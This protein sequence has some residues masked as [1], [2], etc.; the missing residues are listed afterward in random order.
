MLAELKGAAAGLD[1][2]LRLRLSTPLYVALVAAWVAFEVRSSMDAV[3]GAESFIFDWD[4]YMEQAFMVEQGETNYSLIRG[5]TG[6]LVYPGGHVAIH[7]AMRRGFDWNCANWT[8]EHAHSLHTKPE[9]YAHRTHRPDETIRRVQ[10]LYVGVYALS[11]AV[12]AGLY[13]VAGVSWAWLPLLSLGTRA[14]NI[15]GLGLFNDGWAMLFAHAGVLAAGLDW[16][17]V[18]TVLL[19]AGVSVKMNVVLFLPA[20][21]VLV[22]R[23]HG[24][25]GVV[26]LG[27][28]GAAVQAAV[29][30]PFLLSAPKDYIAGA[31]NLGRLFTHRWSINWQHV[32][33]DVFGSEAFRT[34]LLVGHLA[35]LVGL[36]LSQWRLVG[37][38][39]A[40]KSGTSL[41]GAMVVRSLLLCNFVGV[42]FARS[43]HYQFLVWYW[44]ALPVLAGSTRL[45]M[46]VMAPVVYYLERAW[47]VHEPEPWSAAAIAACHLIIL[48]AQALAPKLRPDAMAARSRVGAALVAWVPAGVLGFK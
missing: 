19:S 27:S 41:Q 33:E 4:A 12:A 30:L 40:A 29:G 24:W 32:P 36:G 48:A 3:G 8:T 38:T 14:R 26:W 18:A 31:F 46:L 5:D 11:L 15:Y 34:A 7:V 20:F 9:G 17:G 6:A 47:N 37:D 1:S 21:G 39:A 22:L 23:R 45:P 2:A 25:R 42:V 10:T 43:L 16:W 13:R 28:L 44:A 35:M